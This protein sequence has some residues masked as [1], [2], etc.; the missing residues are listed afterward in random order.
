MTE[1]KKR[2][3]IITLSGSS[4]NSWKGVL[5]IHKMIFDM[6]VIKYLFKLF[7]RIKQIY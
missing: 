4:E 5:R 7:L 2:E 3:W 1:N 6:K